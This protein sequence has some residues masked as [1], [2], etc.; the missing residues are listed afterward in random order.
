LI[1]NGLKAM[2]T[3]VLFDLG[4]TLVRY[5]D[6]SEFPAVLE[7][8]VIGAQQ[9]LH[10]EGLPNVP[11]EVMWRRVQE[12]DYESADLRVRPLEGRLARI[13]G[14]EPDQADRVGMGLCQAFLEPIFARAYCYEDTC[15]ALDGLKRRGFR[16]ALVSNSP[17][18]SPASLWREEVRRLGL[19][20]FLDA[21]IFCGDVGWR[22]PARQIFEFALEKLRVSRQEC[23][24]VG[25]D[26]RWDLAGAQA[27]GM[28]AIL[29]DRGGGLSKAG[30]GPIGSLGELE[31]R[32]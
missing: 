6:R 13:F 28:E 25:D 22:K 7:Q 27:I 31:Q 5:F 17:W 16:L 11:P 19:D 15:P 18:G 8:A 20:P 32:L 12:E 29:I 10:Q 23:V 9:H 2:K 3:T 21:T 30:T 24:F 4:N 26:P 1:R 14:L